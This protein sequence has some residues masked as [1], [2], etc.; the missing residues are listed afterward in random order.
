LLPITETTCDV[1]SSYPKPITEAT[2]RIEHPEVWKRETKRGREICALVPLGIKHIGQ[3][4]GNQ[5]IS[6]PNDPWETFNPKKNPMTLSELR[7]DE[8]IF[9]S[10]KSRRQYERLV[11]EGFVRTLRAYAGRRILRPSLTDFRSAHA[12][13]FR[14]VSAD[15]GSIRDSDC[16]VQIFGSLLDDCDLEAEFDLLGSQISTLHSRAR[17]IQDGVVIVAYTHARIVALQPSVFGNKRAAMCLSLSQIRVLYP[18]VLSLAPLPLKAYYEAL[19]AAI[20]G[21]QIGRLNEVL[22][23]MMG[24]SGPFNSS[25]YSVRSGENSRRSK[26]LRQPDPEMA[27]AGLEV[28]IEQ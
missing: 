3:I 4:V 9:W 15:A 17:T 11:Q 20:S 5:I 2:R 28:L 27:W 7:D 19:E 12:D 18:I 21:D 6:A 1:F 8:G 13:I 14:G 24:I 10:I 23:R 25:G 26:K 16:L 22:G